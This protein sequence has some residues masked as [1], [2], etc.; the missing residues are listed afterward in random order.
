M[1]PRLFCDWMWL[2]EMATTALRMRMPQACSA[3][4]TATPT[5][6]RADWMLSM[7]PRESPDAGA[8]PTPRMRVSPWSPMSPTSTVTFV[9]PTSIA[10]TV[11]R[12]LIVMASPVL[13]LQHRVVAEA[14]V[15]RRVVDLLHLRLLRERG[16]NRE[17]VGD[18]AGIAEERRL[19]V[20]RRDLD[21]LPGDE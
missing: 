14:E 8:T 10:A 19:V 7:T 15:H 1:M 21:A 6:S 5:A 13:S 20:R 9:E 11:F 16:P 18:G 4:S 3:F 17:L 12:R 2:P